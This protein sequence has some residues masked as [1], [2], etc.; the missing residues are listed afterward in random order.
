VLRPLK[1]IAPDLVHPALGR[2]IAAL[3]ASL[4]DDPAMRRMDETL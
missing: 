2:T 4:P 1:D 3:H